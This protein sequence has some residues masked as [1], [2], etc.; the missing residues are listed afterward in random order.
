MLKRSLLLT[1]VLFASQSFAASFD[2]KSAMNEMK[3][4]FKQA[5]EAQSIE[6]MSTAM[7][8]FNQVLDELQQANYPVE[9][10]A[11]YN[12]GFDQLELVVENVEQQLESGDLQQAKE[13]LRTI[14]DLRV[15][16]HDK[17]NPS[18]WSKLFG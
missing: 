2:I 8:S 4:S 17:R 11:L 18:I 15:E 1:M 5:A 10:Q 7:T 14:D 3:L 16:F 13:Q 9:K 12:E 6:E